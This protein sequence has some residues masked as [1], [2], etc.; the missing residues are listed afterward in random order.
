M[1]AQLG[2]TVPALGVFAF[3]A[4]IAPLMDEFWLSL[5]TLVLF[6]ALLGVAWNLVMG[7]AG[8]LS[9]GHALYIGLG[10]YT[11]VLLSEGAGISPWLGISAGAMIAAAAGAVI[12]LLSFRF[13]L[14]GIYFALLTIAFAEIIRVLFDNWK[15]VGGTAGYF[16]P[17][18]DPSTNNPLVSL[19][20][21]AS[22][23]YFA[24]LI[25]LIVAYVAVQWL[26]ESKLGYWWQSIREDEDVARSLGVPA[27]PCKVAAVAISAAIA[28][29]AGGLYAL[30]QGSLF[31]DTIMG[32]R[33]S[34]ELIIAPIIGGLGTM[35]GPMIG[36]LFVVPVMHLSN[37]LSG[38]VGVAGLNTL[39]Y[40]LVVFLV[41]VF[42]PNGI[43]PRLIAIVRPLKRL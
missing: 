28:G 12:A 19:R 36:A 32:M 43:W 22:F 2:R 41:V 3:L 24:F 27:L 37:Y 39:I 14:R 13:S 16:L 34:I 20:G 40:G 10:G 8:L 9:L 38:R 26:L 42:M 31:P 1:N 33:M 5:L 29:I 18:L 23:F 30:L 7:F 11:T 17:A 15:L 4:A 21:G 6:Y 25:T 35:F